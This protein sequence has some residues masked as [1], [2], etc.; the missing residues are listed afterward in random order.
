MLNDKKNWI[1][2]TCEVNAEF[3]ALQEALGFDETLTALLWTRGIRDFEAARR[4][5]RPSW[6][7]L[8]NPLLM[9]DMDI[10]VPRIMRAINEGETLMIYG[11]YDVDGTTAVA[12][13]SS[14]LSNFTDRI[15]TYTPDR[16]KEGYGLSMDGIQF[17]S[18]HGCTVLIALDC[19]IK[20]VEQAKFASENGIDLIIGDHHTPGPKL[21]EAFAILDPKRSD[22]SYPYDELSGCGIGFKICQA[23]NERFGRPESELEPLL[24]LLVVSIGAD[25]VP[26]TGENR[27]LAQLGLERLNRNPRP[28]FRLIMQQAK[29][30]VF[31]I[32]D[33]VFTIAPRINAAG[34][35]DHA[36]AAVQLLNSQNTH[37]AQSILKEIN[38]F[39][40]TRKDLD[41]E[42]AASALA[43]LEK[44]ADCTY[45]SVVFDS[46][47]HKGVIGIAASR[48]IET[49][50]RP[51]VV[52][53]ENKGILAGSARSVKGFNVYDALDACSEHLI[54]FG[55]H[56]YAAGMTMAPEKYHDF[57]SAFENYVRENISEEQKVEDLL[58]DASFDVEDLNDQWMRRLMFFHPH[59]PQNDLPTF[60]GIPKGIEEVKVIGADKSHLKFKWKGVDCIAFG[61]ANWLEDLVNERVKIAYHLEYNEFRNVKFEQVRVI[62]IK[63]LDSPTV[64]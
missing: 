55:G 52:F 46:S 51:T 31:D 63:P 53:T 44:D 28:G 15:I 56:K 20:A 4:F 42:T 27:I 1:T 2:R 59:G 62:D 3:T 21:P 33:V 32:T 7:Y 13:V 48:L 64:G 50:Y 17:A 30:S 37:E 10:V 25:I 26:I 60:I 54:Q 5:F 45:S 57:K 23:L 47:W 8:H 9:K 14:Y 11:D 29:K 19:G 22:C 38:E 16:Y 24:D 12:L 35:I 18:D 39:N 41:K 49:Y 58:I 6:S 36:N 61:C 40:Q 34:R 43:M